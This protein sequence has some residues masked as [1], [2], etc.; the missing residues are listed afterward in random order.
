MESEF[1]FKQIV[2]CFIINVFLFLL[3]AA[4]CTIETA[5]Y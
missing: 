2:I 4:I 5:S 1:T 3:S